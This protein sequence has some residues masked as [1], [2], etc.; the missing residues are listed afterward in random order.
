MEMLQGKLSHGAPQWQTQMVTILVA[1]EN[2]ASVLQIV[3]IQQQILLTQQPLRLQVQ[4]NV[5]SASNF[6]VHI[7]VNRE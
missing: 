4:D 6:F 7:F 3:E 5:V 1:K 2:G